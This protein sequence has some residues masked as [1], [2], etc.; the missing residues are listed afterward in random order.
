MVETSQV[1]VRLRSALDIQTC[2][3][4]S[5][6]HLLTF[7]RCTPAAAAAAEKRGRD[8]AG[9]QNQAA[10]QL[11]RQPGQARRL[12]LACQSSYLSARGSL[13]P[14]HTRS[15]LHRMA[16]LSNNITFAGDG[17]SGLQIGLN[18]GAIHVAAPGKCPHPPQPALR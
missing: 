10:D 11:K 16:Y 3:R 2:L 8:Y 14:T 1:Q 13:H 4:L 18:S 17:N 15:L 6:L 7:F 9:A 5:F 12:S